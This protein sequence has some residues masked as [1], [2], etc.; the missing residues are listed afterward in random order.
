MPEPAP[1][2]RGF[3]ALVVAQFVGAFTDNAFLALCA[4]AFLPRRIRAA[5][6]LYPAFMAPF[7]LLSLHAGRVA[8]RFSKKS[9]IVA[10]RV[11]S[12][13]I[14]L[15]AAFAASPR[16]PSFHLAAALLLGAAA[17]YFGPSKYGIL[18]ELVPGH[19]LSRANGVVQVSAIAAILLG[20]AGGWMLS[21]AG[22]FR[23]AL[24]ALAALAAA[25]T[26]ASLF[27]TPVKA[28]DPSKSL[29]FR[30]LRDLAD[31][32]SAAGKD[33]VLRLAVLGAAFLW[34]IGALLLLASSAA[35]VAALYLAMAAGLG[36][37][38]YLAG[39]LSGEKV[40][41]GLIPLGALGIA[42][43]SLG[44]ALFSGHPPFCIAAAALLGAGGGFFAI[45][46][47]AILQQRPAPS[48]RG[49]IQGLSYLLSSAAVLCA[50]PLFMV[51]VDAFVLSHASV[52][53]FVSALTVAVTACAL[54]LVPDSLVR[55]LLWLLTHTFYRIRVVGR[56]NLPPTGG[57]LLVANHMSFADALFVLASTDR[58][59]R[60]VIYR[61]VYEIPAIRPFARLMRAIPLAAGD[62]PR[63]L[64]RA[65]REATD[66]IRA[67]DLVCIFAEGQIT[68][69]GQM[70]PFRQGFERIMKG[71]E[72][73][74]IPVHL[75]RVWGSIFSFEK[76]RFVWKWPR[77]VPYPITVSYGAPMPPSSGAQEVR[78]AVQE[79]STD[80]FR[81]R[82]EEMRPL[83]R[84]FIAEARR[85]PWRFAM[86]D[87][88][89]PRVSF[90]GVLARSVALARA[91]RGRWGQGEMAGILLP[92]SVVAACA[93]IAALLSGKV[94]VNLNYT[95]SQGSFDSSVSQCGIETVVTSR[96]F[97]EKIKVSPRGGAVCLEEIASGISKACRVLALAMALLLPARLLERALGAK[98]RWSLDDLAT[99]IFSSGS[100]G[101]PKGV[102]LTHYNIHANIEGI[103]QVMR[104]EPRDRV[105]GVLP[106]FHSFGFTG[107]LFFPLVK[108]F[109][110]VYHPNPMDARA[111]G[112]LAARHRATIFVATP[113]FLQSYIRRV[114][115][116][117][118]GSLRFVLTGAEKLPDR[119]AASFEER[120]GIRPYEAYGCTECAPAVTVNTRG[121]RA[122]GFYQVG[123][124]RGMIGHPLPGVSVR[125]VDPDTME[126]LPAGRPGLL[127]VK[128]PNVMRGYLGNP[129]TTAEVLVDGWYRTG[130][131]AALDEDGFLVITDRLSRFAKI[132][133]EMVPL[134]RI[135][136]RLHELAGLA[137]QSLAVA[138]VPD[139]KKGERLA[140]L[141][142]LDEAAIA[143][144]LAALPSSGLPN[145]WIP[146]PDAFRRIDALPVLGTGKLDLRKINDLARDVRG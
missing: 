85:R 3:R 77:R 111:V 126:P 133:G 96:A 138:A 60:F 113:T 43:G 51:F 18:P 31:D 124:K 69:T 50:I 98:R 121:Y 56:A 101:E 1:P 145:L 132:G 35:P 21:G 52:P 49:A 123:G 93:N 45:P 120:F 23:A 146:R 82:R 41:Y 53:Y 117:Q 62:D 28:A 34:F 118:F 142:T 6:S 32:W 102:M 22:E 141:H 131:I 25:G 12:L 92:P 17:A 130:D 144:L 66:G 59:V 4:A 29:A 125:I 67:G 39:V 19:R 38:G 15:L 110:A 105:L 128:G 84:A 140:V 73:P 55:L 74:I 68:R 76:G 8:D 44:I 40:E 24:R 10:T 136:E 79:L 89:T 16:A 114:D 104:T 127:L 5:E 112:E 99:V 26:L 103:A 14:L 64:I 95:V 48:S 42:A 119:V 65:L 91:M 83:H 36:I 33:T 47:Y 143:A 86:A 37:G 61:G 90:L 7:L 13:L 58:Q 129:E 70:L 109:G 72:A 87:G 57:A 9:V 30:P 71:V 46:L 139:E 54:S 107:T 134:V 20:Q 106:F 94:P 2:R 108:G 80:A 115:P 137:Q 97:L 100:T 88:S 81:F 135:E 27:I 11:A 122:P 75:D 63:E 116:G 78:R